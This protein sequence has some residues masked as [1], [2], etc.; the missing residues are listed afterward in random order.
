MGLDIRA[1]N[2]IITKQTEPEA[3]ELGIIMNEEPDQFY[4]NPDFP[5]HTSEY[6]TKPGVVEYIKS[7][8]STTESFRAGSY[9]GYNKWRNLLSLAL[10]G[11]KAETAWENVSKYQSYP[12]WGIINFSDCEGAFDSVKSNNVHEELVDNR[13]KFVSY[14]KNDTDIGDMDT[15][16]YIETYDGM[17]R[18]FKLA[19]EAGVLIYG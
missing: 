19:S 14:I 2:K 7:E 6:G 16:H 3:F 8:E 18:C 4:I 10:L 15:E 5:D 12:A 11:V 1:V 9:S 17:I 13:D